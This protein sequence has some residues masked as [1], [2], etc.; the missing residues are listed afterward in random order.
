MTF[1]LIFHGWKFSRILISERTDVQILDLIYVFKSISF[2]VFFFS[3]VCCFL[4]SLPIFHNISLWKEFPYWLV[5]S[6]ILT[7]LLFHSSAISE[8]TNSWVTFCGKSFCSSRIREKHWHQVKFFASRWLN[9]CFNCIF[10]KPF[11]S[12]LQLFTSLRVILVELFYQIKCLFISSDRVAS[13]AAGANAWQGIRWFQLHH[14]HQA[15]AQELPLKI[16]L[17]NGSMDPIL[18]PSGKT[19]S[20]DVNRVY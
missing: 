18:I 14:S 5:F 4:L 3:F 19:L 10:S 13:I 8:S 16:P 15:M 11:R 17:A 12:A 1:F 20:L 7:W 9:V 6:Q 2:T